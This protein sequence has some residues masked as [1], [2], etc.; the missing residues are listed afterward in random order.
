MG[1]VWHYKDANIEL[2]RLAINGLD[3]TSTLRGGLLEK[4]V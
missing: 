3:R 4:K 2:I 1:E